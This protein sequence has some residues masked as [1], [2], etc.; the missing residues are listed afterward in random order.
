MPCSAAWPPRN[1]SE[2]PVKLRVL[3]R[4]S[5]CDGMACEH[6]G[7]PRILGTNLGNYLRLSGHDVLFGQRRCAKQLLRTSDVVVHSARTMMN[8]PRSDKLL[9]R[10][11]AGRVVVYGNINTVDSD[12]VNEADIVIA[13]SWLH[14]HSSRTQHDASDARMI[15]LPLL[16]V[17][18]TYWRR[19]FARERHKAIH[20]TDMYKLV[21]NHVPRAVSQAMPRAPREGPSAPLLCYHG[22][23]VH[24]QTA[25]ELWDALCLLRHAPATPIIRV[26]AIVGN[27]SGAGGSPQLAGGSTGCAGVVVEERLYHSVDDT[28]AQL[29]RCDLGLVPN[30][31][32]TAWARKA[33]T[34][35][36]TP[37]VMLSYKTS[38]NGGRAMV[39]A[40]VGL[41]FVGSPELE[42]ARL[43]GAAGLPADR[44]FAATSEQWLHRLHAW[45]HDDEARA[46]ASKAL[47]AYAER[48]LLP[49][50]LARLVERRILQARKARRDRL[51]AAGLADLQRD[52]GVSAS[53]QERID[54]CYCLEGASSAHLLE[55]SMR[56]IA[57]AVAEPQRLRFHLFVDNASSLGGIL[58]RLRREVPHALHG[59]RVYTD[60]FAN[61]STHRAATLPKLRT[62]ANYMRFYLPR[63]LPFTPHTEPALL[64]ALCTLHNCIGT[65]SRALCVCC[66]CAAPS[67]CGQ[68]A[69]SRR[70]HG[71]AA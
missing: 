62:R 66:R 48:E 49:S 40:Q 63:A 57:R 21:P 12:T 16:E 39:M 60:S 19:V 64:T 52:P 53:V 33:N 3:V 23:R 8:P 42:A 24:L 26:L 67:G 69:L 68:A 41:P 35:Q 27:S 2:Q 15:V 28:Y 45:L 46:H 32:D 58:H 56:S 34:R 61:V 38:A 44:M 65:D 25:R 29:S 43:V 22:N 30:L 14:G 31:E 71:R 20:P 5:P 13:D 37:T 17:P 47:R 50:T 10:G 59:T 36:G 18:T 6:M 4:S 7:S 55:R 11:D 51:R 1:A 70:G 9:R 54:V